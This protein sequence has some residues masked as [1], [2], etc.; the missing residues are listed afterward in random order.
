MSSDVRTAARLIAALEERGFKAGG[1]SPVGIR[2]PIPEYLRELWGRR[3]FIWMDSQ[4]RVATQNSRNRLGR[5]WLVLRPLLDAAFYFLIFGL[6]LDVQGRVEDYAAFLIIGVLTF[7]AMARSLTQGPSLIH[8]NK[9]MIRAFSF[10]RISIPLSFQIREG[11]QLGPTMLVMLVVIAVIP[12]FV[13]PTWT[14]LLMVPIL[15]MQLFVNL[16]ISLILARVGFRFPDA[17]HVMSLVSRVAMYAGGVIFPIEQFVDHHLIARILT[18]NPLYLVIDMLREVL[19][20]G[21][22]PMLE[23]WLVLLAWSVGLAGIGFL[24]F[25]WGEASYGGGE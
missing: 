21:T 3:H 17:Q 20:G 2:P 25:W 15:A 24:V 8:N 4:H 14:W 11:L 5:L 16:G 18:L 10:P 9:S 23:S 7:Q 19:M 1:L 13:T 6:L 22:V 12:P